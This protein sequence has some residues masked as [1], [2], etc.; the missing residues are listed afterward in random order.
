LDKETQETST[1]LAKKIS[2]DHKYVVEINGIGDIYVNLNLRYVR[3]GSATQ[4]KAERNSNFVLS[5][6]E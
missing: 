1:T 5:S 3:I 6:E 4:W 2:K